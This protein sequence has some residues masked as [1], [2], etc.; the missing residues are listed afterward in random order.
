MA[1]EKEPKI[2]TVRTTANRE[3]QVMGFV[4]SIARRKNLDVYSVIRAHG[5]R[6]YIFVEAATKRDVEEAS[7]NVQYS[8]GVLDEPVSYIEVEHMLE[9]IKREIN[10][11][12]NDIAEIISGPFKRE[13]C[14]IKGLIKIKKKLWLNWFMQQFL[15]Q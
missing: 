5:M 3:S 13:K 11:Q 6:G 9:P 12:P 4:T 7:Y 10:I 1:E 8:K 14:K 15:Y 2:F